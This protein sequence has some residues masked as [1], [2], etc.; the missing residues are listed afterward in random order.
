MIDWVS[1]SIPIGHEKP[2]NGGNVVSIDSDGN[3]E[4]TTE[5]RLS[6]EGS[7][8]STI[9]IRSEH[10]GFYCSHIRMDG[11]FVKFFQGHNVWGTDDLVGLITS[12][13]HLV[14]LSV[15]PDLLDKLCPFSV[16]SWQSAPA[17]FTERVRICHDD[18]DYGNWLVSFVWCSRLTRVDLTEMYDVGTQERALTWLRAAQDSAN[19]KYRGK[20]NFKGET[21]Y[22]GEKSR[23][24]SLKF[25]AKGK[26][27]KAH[28]PKKG[29]IDHPNYLAGV[30][31]FADRALRSEL[32]LRGMELDRLGLSGVQDWKDGVSETVYNSYLSGLEFSQNMKFTHSLP[33]LEKL[34]SR[35]IGPVKLWHSG[36]DLRVLYSRATWYRYKK[37]ILEVSGIDISLPPPVLSES[38]S[39]VVPLIRIIEAVPMSVPA[40]AKGTELYFQ[41][42]AYDFQPLRLVS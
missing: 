8:G 2:I 42:P 30:T 19:L 41:P 12:C 33:D 10:H 36:D 18:A 38:S 6:V 35:L 40:W 14:L 1:V 16:K 9:Q 26:E 22:F 31:D 21:L 27:L 28:K 20:G 25:Y 4:W 11:N 23:R 29:V 5:K 3:V 17:E 32:T 34:P 15:A 13:L 7:Y 24:W 37:E 39:N